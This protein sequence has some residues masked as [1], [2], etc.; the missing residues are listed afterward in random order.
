MLKAWK[1]PFLPLITRLGKSREARLF[2]EAPILIGGCGRS[3]TTLLLSM[4]SAHKDLFAIP[5]ELGLFNGVERGPEG[6]LQSARIDRLYFSLLR[7]SIPASAKRWCEKSPS[8]VT[9]I[10]AIDEH[11]KGRFKLIHI[12]RDGRDVVLSIHPTDKTKY[13]VEPSRWVHDVQKGLDFIDHPNVHTIKYEDLLL[14]YST[15]MEGI[16][17]F[18]SLDF[19]HEL[20]QWHEHATVRRNRAYFS[21]VGKIQTKSIGKWKQTKDQERVEQL[22]A[23]PGALELLQ[24]LGYEVPDDHSIKE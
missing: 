8:N 13:W 19:S 15:V 22:Y 23:E 16:T 18:L 21:E 7:Y 20:Q 17:Q 11:F 5:K 12:V 24:R 14:D 9:Q 4:L 3:G 1:K 6:R 2:S 10:Q